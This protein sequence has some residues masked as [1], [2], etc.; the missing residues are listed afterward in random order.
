M[1]VPLDSVCEYLRQ[2]GDLSL[3]ELRQLAAEQMGD[4][5]STYKKHARGELLAM[6]MENCPEWRGQPPVCTR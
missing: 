2:W 3:T 6:L 4:S 1:N 5:L